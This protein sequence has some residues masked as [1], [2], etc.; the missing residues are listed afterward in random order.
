MI[1]FLILAL[2]F[3]APTWAQTHIVQVVT[4][5]GDP[6]AVHNI[7]LA[8]T[9]PD[10][11]LMFYGQVGN[12]PPTIKDEQGNI[13]QQANKDDLEVWYVGASKGGSETITFTYP[14][15]EYLHIIIVEFDGPY[16][17]SEVIPS[18][19]LPPNCA[20]LNGGQSLVYRDNTSTPSSA[21]LTTT[22]PN[23]LVIGYG[24][25]DRAAPFFNIMP[26]PGWTLVGFIPNRSLQY[27]VMPSP[28][29]VTSSFSQP[30]IPEGIYATEG[31]I[32]FRPIGSC[33]L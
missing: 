25:S 2:L 16:E 5:T 3:A 22:V 29:T 30:F 13:W 31:I 12:N 17:L 9:Q 14:Y 6:Y 11:M 33:R 20:P 23:E 19:C 27:M 32:A 8:P 7:P 1:R 10:H 4:H 21:P 28:G 24:D 15:P 18:R 26:G